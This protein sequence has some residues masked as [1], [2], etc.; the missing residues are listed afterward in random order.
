MIRNMKVVYFVRHG[1]S[2]ANVRAVFQPTTSPLTELGKKQARD[3]AERVK[4]LSVEVLITSPLTRAVETAAY[5]ERYTKVPVVS[6][7]LFRERQKPRGIEGKSI[8]DPDAQRIYRAW[9]KTL[10]SKRRSVRGGENYER[11]A[12]RAARALRF[13]ETRPESRI[14]V[15]SHGFFMRVLAAHVIHKQATPKIVRAFATSLDMEN[16]GL[17]V[18][19]YHEKSGWHVWIWNDHSHLG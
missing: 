3:I 7:A 2:E 17:T 9:T 1:Q 8:H 14:A 18:F 11:L 4:K 5:I 12:A 15:V 10:F 13:L 16:T 19:R 6:N